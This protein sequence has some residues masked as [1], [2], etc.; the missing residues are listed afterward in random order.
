MSVGERSRW[1]AMSLGERSRWI[2][3]YVGTKDALDSN[4]CE[5]KGHVGY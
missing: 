4:V 3:M 1:I 2:A 5:E